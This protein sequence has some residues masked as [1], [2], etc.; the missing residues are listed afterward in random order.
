[1]SAAVDGAVAIFSSFCDYNGVDPSTRLAPHCGPQWHL[2][3]GTSEASPELAGI[4]AIADQA[5]GHRIGWLNPALYRLAEQQHHG[6]IADVE[7]GSNSYAFCSEA[8]GIAGQ[9]P[10]V[11][12][13][14][15]ATE[16]YDMASGLGTIDAARF[17]QA[18]ADLDAGAG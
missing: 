2:G 8:C 12:P 4:V 6:G 13:G 18:I 17:V 16:G 7:G 9:T 10:T 1:M 3:A 5:A 14:F 15:Q 11:V